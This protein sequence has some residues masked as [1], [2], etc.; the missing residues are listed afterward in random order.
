MDVTGGTDLLAFEGFTLDRANRRLS[1]GG[2]PVELGSRYL[3]ALLLLVEEPGTLVTKQRFMDEVWRGIPVTDEALTQGIRTL[4]RALGE[5]AGEA[6]FIETVPKHGYRF[7]APVHPASDA[8]AHAEGNR[9]VSPPPRAAPTPARTGGRV[10]GAVTIGGGLAGAL[11]GLFYGTVITT[12][13]TSLLVMILLVAALGVLG[14]AGIGLGMGAGIAWRGDGPAAR[15]GGGA[16]GGALIGACGH[17]L[18]RDGLLAFTGIAIGRITGPF[19]GL[20]LGGAA[21][22]SAWI[23]AKKSWPGRRVVPAAAAMGAGTGTII[24]LSGGALLGRSLLFLQAEFP[25]SEL[26]L[27]RVGQMFGDTA[28]GA[29]AQWATSALEGALFCACIAFAAR[30]AYRRPM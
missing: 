25:G 29:G 28:F 23:A 8:P 2:A 17:I 27:D 30:Q 4:R 12:G 7:V 26:D 15:I 5:R 21:G 16:M 3:D 24:S 14:A 13:G 1:R 6:R 19:E 20:L 18:G 11:G 10:A 22:L 9:A